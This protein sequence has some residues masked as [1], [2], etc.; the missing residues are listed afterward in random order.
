MVHDVGDYQAS[1]VP[2]A[3]DFDRLDPRFRLSDAVRSGHPDYR[4]RGFAVFK[5]RRR[6]R[7]ADEML[8][9]L[10]DGGLISEQRVA[11]PWWRRLWP[12]RR[13]AKRSLPAPPDVDRPTGEHRARLRPYG[14]P[15][16]ATRNAP[17][18][19]HLADDR[20]L[21]RRP[22]AVPPSSPQGEQ[23]PAI[24]MLW[25]LAAASQALP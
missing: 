19:G 14:V 4:D 1:N 6:L 22:G 5:L 11:E 10:R 15:V 20:G 25:R 3:R 16:E 12:R 21:N 7:A 23:A 9:R 8:A 24:R 17:Q 18:P 2:T 13:P